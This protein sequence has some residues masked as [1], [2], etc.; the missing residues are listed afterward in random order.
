MTEYMTL[1]L[2]YYDREIIEMIVEKYDYS[3]MEAFKKFLNSETYKMLKNIKL[4][5]W[6][7]GCPAIFEMWECEQIAGTPLVS[8]YFR[9]N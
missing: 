2:D 7:F 8:S 1:F 6:E 3:Y 5:M 4:E 9:E